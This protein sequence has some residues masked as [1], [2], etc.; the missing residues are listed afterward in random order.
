MANEQPHFRKI[1]LH[2]D[3]HLNRPEVLT[4][5]GLELDPQSR[6]DIQVTIVAFSKGEARKNRDF[7]YLSGF[8]QE[9]LFELR[10]EL[11]LGASFR[12]LRLIGTELSASA[13]LLLAWHLKD[14]SLP[15]EAQRE[16]MNRACR[17]A[18]ERKQS[19]D[20]HYH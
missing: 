6:N 7:K 15:S 3:L 8:R 18:I 10:W 20:I 17:K 16:L 1:L 13:A 12:P 14:P 11:Q 2:P 4:E 9:R 5:L 19:I